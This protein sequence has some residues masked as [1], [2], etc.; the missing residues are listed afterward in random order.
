M[1]DKIRAY[2]DDIVEQ[3]WGR[4]ERNRMEFAI[5]TR[6]LSQHLPG[7]GRVLDCGGGPGRYALWLAERG[8]DVSLIDLSP[9]CPE[10]A[11]REAERASLRLETAEG[12]ATD[13]SRFSDESFDAALLLGPLYHLHEQDEREQAVL[14]ICRV[15]RPGGLIAAGFVTRTAPLRFLAKEATE[16]TLELLDAMRNVLAHGWDEGFPPP[17]EPAFYAYFAHPSEVEPLLR[18][19]DLEVLGVYAAEGFVSMIDGAL[20]ELEGE[21]WDAW[22]PLNSEL[23]SDPT[24]LSGAEHLV[25]LARRPPR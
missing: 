7:S 1:R 25:A 20:N 9:K 11:Q 19:A 10:W 3:E 18:T 14:E 5:T 15:V 12:T 8:Y 2:Y 24:L 4:L 16:R 23:A 22:V 6:Y 21:A 17:D 13:L